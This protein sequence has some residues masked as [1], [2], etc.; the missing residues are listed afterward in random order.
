M[1]NHTWRPENWDKT[2]QDVDLPSTPFGL[3]PTEMYSEGYY[4]GFE[5][6]ADA[7]LDSI[8]ID[9]WIKFTDVGLIVAS[10]GAIED[11]KYRKGG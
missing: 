5:A 4:S 11:L 2:V 10:G 7:I 6:G 3:T 8:P 9:V 1:A